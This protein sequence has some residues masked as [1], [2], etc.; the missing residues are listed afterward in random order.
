MKEL[1]SALNKWVDGIPEHR[2]LSS[3]PPFF[4]ADLMRRL[5]AA[6]RWDLHRAD[7]VFFNQSVARYTAYY[8]VQMTARRLFIPMVRTV[9]TVRTR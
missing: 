2:A 4:S 5:G 8:L 6:V 3:L 9:P 1:D 7:P